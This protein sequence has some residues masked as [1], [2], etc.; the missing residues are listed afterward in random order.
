M[1][2]HI[3]VFSVSPSIKTIRL[4]TFVVVIFILL[5]SCENSYELEN[6]KIDQISFGDCKPITKSSENTERIEYKTVDGNYLPIKHVN[7]YFNCEPGQLLVNI[8]IQNDSIVINEDE[9]QSIANCICPYDL[10]FR[11][12]PMEYG[13][14][15]FIITKGYLYYTKFTIVFNSQTDGTFMIE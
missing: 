6:I 10:S 1:K 14:Y 2:N 5:P 11:V 12:G 15:N 4:I 8:K 9:E 3:S 13:T 7:T